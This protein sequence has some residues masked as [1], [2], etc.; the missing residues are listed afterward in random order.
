MDVSSMWD[1]CESKSVV[2]A[3]TTDNVVPRKRRVHVGWIIRRCVERAVCQ[4]DVVRQ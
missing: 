3:E 1:E 4:F 2:L